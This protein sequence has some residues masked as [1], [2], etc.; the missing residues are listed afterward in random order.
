M[1][2]TLRR[3]DWVEAF[4]AAAF[5]LVAPSDEVAAA[6]VTA[7]LVARKPLRVNWSGMFLLPFVDAE[8]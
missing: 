1:R 8:R 5:G 4:V 6:R 3:R 2:P 7:A